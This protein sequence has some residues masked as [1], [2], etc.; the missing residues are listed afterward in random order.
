MQNNTCSTTQKGGNC[1]PFKQAVTAFPVTQ[2]H[3]LTMNQRSYSFLLFLRFRPDPT[4][5]KIY[6]III[7]YSHFMFGF[8]AEKYIF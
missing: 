7:I 6:N 2:F 1:L 5:H 4:I 8:K 3:F